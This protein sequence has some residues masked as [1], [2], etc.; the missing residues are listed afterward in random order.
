M[1]SSMLDETTRNDP[2]TRAIII[3]YEFQSGKPISECYK[4]FRNR[5][6]SDYVDYQEFKLWFQ[7]F[8]AGNFDLN[9]DKSQDTKYRTIND[10]PVHIFEKICSNLGDDHQEKYRFILRYV[11][12]S[13]RS[14]VN[15]WTPKFEN[16]LIDS[17]YERITVEFDDKK[18]RYHR[19]L[20]P[21]LTQKH[22]DFAL[23]DL[24]SVLNFPNFKFDKLQIGQKSIIDQAFL[25][26][27]LL[28]IE[29]LNLKI[30]AKTVVLNY[31]GREIDILKFCEIPELLE[32]DNSGKARI[33]EIFTK[34]NKFGYSI[35]KKDE[36][37]KKKLPS[38]ILTYQKQPTAS[39][40]AEI[41][42][43]LLQYHTLEYC[44]LDGPSRI[45]SFKKKI[46]EFGAKYVPSNESYFLNFPI[47]DSLDFF[48]IECSEFIVIKKKKKKT[49]SIQ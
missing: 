8:S 24:I 3:F 26:K 5:M 10:L 6:G 37:F 18:C 13:F 38:I 25:E 29:S 11:C 20:T 15:S 46:L 34:L 2:K 40:A 33:D 32:I 14:F 1:A 28:K 43:T 47:P 4:N 19:F 31:S 23:D 17:D 22:H 45:Q 30:H 16:I 7:R 49:I 48:E 12:E 9:Y 44:Q 27:L 35:H 21:F 41:V 36:Q 39:E 42:K